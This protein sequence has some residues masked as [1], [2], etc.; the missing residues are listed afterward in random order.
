[1]EPDVSELLKEDAVALFKRAQEIA[2][3]RESRFRWP[4]FF[5]TNCTVNPRCRH[6][7]W[8]GSRY[9]DTDW[10]RRYSLEEVVEKATTLE[11]AGIKKTHLV[12]GWMGYEVPEYYYDYISAIKAKTHLEIYGQFGPLSRECL[13]RLKKAGMDGYWTGIEVMNETAFK[14]LR[15]GDSLEAR[16]KTL[17]ET[18]E[19]GLGVWSSFLI[20]VGET[21][22]DVAREIEFVKELGIGSL[23]VI[24][25][26]PVP[27]TEME[28]AE[29]PN[30]YRV[31]KAMA[32]ARISLG[33]KVDIVSFTGMSYIEWGIRAG[34]N[35]FE[36]SYPWEMAK[37]DHL[38]KTFYASGAH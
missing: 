1:M 37:I 28:R 25:L 29:F 12:S 10:I 31:A 11:K 9:Y 2:K 17:R 15:P 16:L 22:E 13:V 19:L 8:Y 38:R 6:C 32:A 34:A 14:N 35:E 4:I 20:G 21:D 26:K 7:F 36:V 24:P 33:E 5:N 30:Q 27:F 23:M 18:K 3:N